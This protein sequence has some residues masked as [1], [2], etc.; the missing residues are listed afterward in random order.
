[1]NFKTLLFLLTFP[2][3]S[4][5]NEKRLALVIG[6]ANYDKGPLENPVNDA[7]LIANTLDSLNFDVILKENI[8]TKTEFIR[9]IR[10]F[11]MKR[12]DYDVAF[13]YYAG[14]GIQIENENFL[15]PIN[16]EFTSEYDVLDFGV[17]VQN[18]MR[19]LES[20]TD[21]V[22]I[23]ILDACRDNP[24]ESTW[25][26]TRS[27]K[28]SGLAKI[29]APTGSLIAFSTDAGQTA[30]DGDGENS[31]YT[32]S[33]AKN[34]LIED[35]SIDQVFRNVRSEVLTET[36]GMQR[37]VEATQ[38]TGQSFYLLPN[39][40][41]DELDEIDRIL[42]ENKNI[43]KALELSNIILS[44]DPNNYKALQKKAHSLK[45]LGDLD[46]SYN[47]YKD[48][49]EI[50][51]SDLSNYFSYI[52]H[53]DFSRSDLG[54]YNRTGDDQKKDLEIALELEEKF[55]VNNNPWLLFH[56]IRKYIR[57][58]DLQNEKL[59]NFFKILSEINLE[60]TISSA[61]QI[62]I[63]NNDIVVDEDFFLA[64][65][66]YYKLYQSYGLDNYSKSISDYEFLINNL[67]DKSYPLANESDIWVVNAYLSN[68]NKNQAIKIL[69]ENLDSK[70][71][72]LI[73]LKEL[74]NIIV[75]YDYVGKDEKKAYNYLLQADSIINNSSLSLFER[76]EVG[77]LNT[78]TI[79]LHQFLFKND[80]ISALK[81]SDD[82]IKNV[83]NS[84]DNNEFNDDAIFSIFYCSYLINI[85]LGRYDDA[86]MSYQLLEKYLKQNNMEFDSKVL[87]IYDKKSKSIIRDDKMS[88]SNDKLIYEDNG[89]VYFNLVTYF[90]PYFNRSY[91]NNINYKFE[92][93]F[94]LDRKIEEFSKINNIDSEKLRILISSQI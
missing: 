5:S 38:L 69:E 83:M 63:V 74:Y 43:D 72:N 10:E 32:L 26:T 1:M 61:K 59:E 92:I 44:N 88:N 18:I 68:G 47:I 48:L 58:F 94:N 8:S 87:G 77:S 20:Q 90:N 85:I 42:L 45:L 2:L 41:K 30:P 17:S 50:D 16:E 76:Q 39:D 6:N 35:I 52:I 24:Y 28:G 49:I 29:P 57:L 84:F 62:F 15:L 91:G 81:T 89:T 34:M 79:I 22:N 40:Y 67:K 53:N 37:P 86:E 12:P 54:L 27:L 23:L 7:R 78:A 56:I 14:H 19:Y 93:L 46:K 4:Y 65:F 71:A 36:D 31:V 60:E 64:Q 73:S 55:E 66:M 70:V 3:V 21:E 82:Y 75:K 80:L 25:N 33:L 9:S 51:S 13:V 11:G